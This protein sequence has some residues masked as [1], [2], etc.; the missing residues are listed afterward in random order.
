MMKDKDL[1]GR[2]SQV[3]ETTMLSVYAP[4]LSTSKQVGR[5]LV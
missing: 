4:S 2:L 1:E 3:C 5:F